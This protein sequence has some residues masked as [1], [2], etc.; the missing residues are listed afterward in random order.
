M[1]LA[2]EN[3]FAEEWREIYRSGI[4]KLL[5]YVEG[6][7]PSITKDDY[8]KCYTI[9]YNLCLQHNE[10]GP[11]VLYQKYRKLCYD[12]LSKSK[13]NSKIDEFDFVKALNFI[14][15]EWRKYSLFTKVMSHIFA[16]LDRFYLKC[17]SFPSLNETGFFNLAI[18]AFISEF[19]E[20]VSNIFNNSIIAGF[21]QLRHHNTQNL[22]LTRDSI[23]L[24]N[25]LNSTKNEKAEILYKN[26]LVFSNLESLF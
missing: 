3:Y 22:Q 12:F 8:S 13:K 20:P 11:K 9:A 10:I 24:H 23:M 2:E 6:Q 4:S 7:K 1:M 19:F 25:Y 21:T 17:N 14:G 18:E 15:N 26:F 16:Y 5:A